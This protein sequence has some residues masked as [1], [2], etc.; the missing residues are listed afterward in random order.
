MLRKIKERKKSGSS[1]PIKVLDVGI[2]TGTQWVDF[3]KKHSLKLGE[4]IEI[5]GS[6]LSR[7]L[8]PDLLKSKVKVCTADNLRKRFKR[9]TYDVVISHMG[10]HFQEHEALEDALYV[11]KRGGE[12]IV[13]GEIKERMP[14]V[15]NKKGEKHYEVLS[16][17]T[18]GLWGYHLR[19]K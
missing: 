5:H 17:V 15:T 11:T 6:G 7:I 3:L 14:K 1:I 13:S 12:I 4:D 9:N 16:K 19:K 10:T 8:I 2:G 18:G